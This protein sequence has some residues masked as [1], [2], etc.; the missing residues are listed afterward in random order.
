M[1]HVY[2]SASLHSL[3]TYFPAKCF[4]N[5]GSR[6]PLNMW[7]TNFSIMFVAICCWKPNKTQLEDAIAQSIYYQRIEQYCIF[8]GIM[9]LALQQVHVLALDTIF[10]SISLCSSL[11]KS[12]TARVLDFYIVI[13]GFT[14]FSFQL[15]YSIFIKK[16]H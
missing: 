9:C 16:S 11:Y 7:R 10:I 15:V 4:H 12:N 1:L 3:Y 8:T 2:Y 14:N 5:C 6:S 13:V